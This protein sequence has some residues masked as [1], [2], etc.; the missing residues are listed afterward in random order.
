MIG[1]DTS[2]GVDVGGTFTDIA[3]WRDGELV[4]GKTS[5]T[6]DQSEGVVAGAIAA[7]AP[8]ASRFL[9]GT[10][11]ATN[12]LLERAG[13][14]TLLVTSEGFE[15][16]VEIGRQDRPSLY[17]PAVVRPAPLAAARLG[18]DT[19]DLDALRER[20]AA[21]AP[22]AVAI[23]LMHAHRD[24]TGEG[25]VRNTLASLGLP[26]SASTDVVPEF[27]EYERTSTTVLNAYLTPVMRRYLDALAER[28]AAAGLPR[29]IQVMR[30]SGGL[31]AIDAAAGLPAAA[32]L[33]GPAGGV[34]A[35]AALAQA[36][37]LVSAIAFD[38][39]GTSTD[40]CRIEGGMPEV[41]YERPIDGHPCRLPSVAVHTVGAG[42]GSLGWL[43]AGGSMR[44]GPQ[45]A[46]AWPGPAAYGRGG[47]A[48][49]VTDANV[50]LGRLGGA[51]A[52][53]V[54]L[55]G[56]AAGAALEGLGGH[57]G[58]DAIATAFGMIEIVEAHMERAIRAVSIEEGADP[59]RAHL[60]AFGGAG[61]LHAT[62]LARRLDMRGVVIPPH[63]GVFSALGLLLSPPRRDAARSVVGR[64]LA[65]LDGVLSDVMNQ[66]RTDVAMGGAR[67]VG[68]VDLRYVGQ[69]H[70]INVPYGPGEGW[71]AAVER[72]HE[73]HRVRNGFARL[74]DPVEAVAVRAVATAPPAVDWEDLPPHRPSESSD[75]GTRT[76]R[77][78]AGDVE[79]RLLARA[80][81]DVGASVAGPAVVLDGEATTWLAAGD[82]GRVHPS[83]ALVVT[84]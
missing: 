5:T 47:V 69:A 50:V 28:A 22:E 30:S 6:P 67:V 38:M 53:G 46:G 7:G 27:R 1:S 40:V 42:G 43:D 23:S 34:V 51:L 32:L 11:V 31:M 62:A 79:A 16:V 20:V 63:A 68:T 77:T 49:T 8:G 55:D 9:H 81:L 54:V 37:G 17:D 14:R 29:D 66:A 82:V 72:F 60:V 75:L 80:E 10:T 35:T 3:V 2:L 70:E 21:A 33:S 13:A 84:W 25:E 61:G 18:V 15:D 71:D 83:G 44:V 78:D 39:G 57:M 52:G 73:E 41:R 59:R 76:V 74:G 12:A 58:L 65:D 24:G 4:V 19:G 26:I 45:S 56:R 36:L 48:P 64:P